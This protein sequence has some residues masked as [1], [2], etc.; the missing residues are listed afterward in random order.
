MGRGNREVSDSTDI[1][2]QSAGLGADTGEPSLRAWMN[3][4][5]HAGAPSLCP[6]VSQPPVGQRKGLCSENSLFLL[7]S[8]F[9]PLGASWS[10]ELQSVAGRGLRA[11]LCG[12]NPTWVSESPSPAN[13]APFLSGRETLY[14]L[15]S[16]H[17]C[18]VFP[19][20]Q[21]L[22]G[23]SPPDACRL[24]KSQLKNRWVFCFVFVLFTLCKL[25]GFQQRLPSFFRLSS[26]FL[27]LKIMDLGFCF[28]SQNF[29]KSCLKLF[30]AVL[31]KPPEK[32]SCF[33]GVR[34]PISPS[35]PRRQWVAL[36]VQP[37]LPPWLVQSFF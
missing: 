31:I 34:D 37:D 10:L 27:N 6:P 25:F 2:H 8:L 30:T 3:L 15:P 9:W 36:A 23:I 21:L 16:M 1:V 22:C 29:L 19:G 14:H 17:L 35:L 7:S 4:E 26:E 33:P 24:Y 11:R 12:A 13:P 32:D 18:A 20:G 28:S 5:M